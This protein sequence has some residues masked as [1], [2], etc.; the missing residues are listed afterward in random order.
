M[1]FIKL[2]ATSIAI[3][4]EKYQTF[5]LLVNRQL[6]YINTVAH[7]N[8][9]TCRL[10]TYIHEMQHCI[11]LCAMRFSA[12]TDVP[13]RKREHTEERNMSPLPFFW[14]CHH[15][16]S[17]GCRDTTALQ[18]EIGISALQRTITGP[19]QLATDE[20]GVLSF[21]QHQRS[22]P[23]RVCLDDRSTAVPSLMCT[24]ETCMF[25]RYPPD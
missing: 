14:H 22:V 4:H 24:H 2:K 8:S 17:P 13:S 20:T 23:F 1:Y 15:K 16:R 5:T 19:L 11:R 3:L 12:S 6:Q 7:I 9:A 10:K 25:L 18:R 21:S